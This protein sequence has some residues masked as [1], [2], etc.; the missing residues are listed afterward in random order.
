ML[1]VGCL[2]P[3]VTLVIGAGLGSYFGGINGGY[4]GSGVGFLVGLLIVVAGL[5]ALTR[6]LSAKRGN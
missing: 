2:I 4:W 6:A 5:G 1:A 3:L